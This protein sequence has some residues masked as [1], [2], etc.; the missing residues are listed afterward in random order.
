MGERGRQVPV[1]RIHR[2]LRSDGGVATPRVDG[3]RCSAIA[4]TMSVATVMSRRVLPA[5]ARVRA[6]PQRERVIRN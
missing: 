1:A 4:A 2:D 3:R 5:P 6:V